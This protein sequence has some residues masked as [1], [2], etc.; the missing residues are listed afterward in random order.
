M[1]EDNDIAVQPIRGVQ[2]RPAGNHEPFAVSYRTGQHGGKPAGEDSAD[3]SLS[4]GAQ[5]AELLFSAA[6]DQIS[7]LAGLDIEP[8]LPPENEL[9]GGSHSQ[10][11]LLGMEILLELYRRQRADLSSQAILQAF[12]PLAR[13]GLE[14]GYQETCQV[15]R[16]LNV[17]TPV[18]ADQL[19]GL[20]LLTQQLFEERLLAV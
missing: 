1:A 12:A 7:R 10:R 2:P 3:I 16:Q 17:Y 19:Q 9:T 15:L 11:L 18:V 20:L 5:A 14:R 13:F 4:Q 8:V 6:M